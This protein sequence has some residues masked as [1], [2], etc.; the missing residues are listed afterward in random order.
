MRSWCKLRRAATRR[1]LTR[2]TSTRSCRL[3][4][5]QTCPESREHI[6]KQAPAFALVP[7]AVQPTAASVSKDTCERQCHAA[8]AV[9]SVVG[10]C[11]RVECWLQGKTG[12]AVTDLYTPEIAATG[13]GYNTLVP[14]SIMRYDTLHTKCVWLLSY[15]PLTSVHYSVCTVATT[16]PWW[17]A[18]LNKTT[19]MRRL[20]VHF[21]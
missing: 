9:I 6:A 12:Q 14:P 16:H 20:L 11:R 3:V 2:A 15:W 19:A 17:I 5:W 21:V 13:S 7:S 18:I 10:G 1:G 4:I 8:G